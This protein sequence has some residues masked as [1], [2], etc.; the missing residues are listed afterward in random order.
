MPTLNAGLARPLTSIQQGGGNLSV[1]LDAATCYADDAV[2]YLATEWA[3]GAG[4][5]LE[6]ALGQEYADAGG[7]LFSCGVY[8]LSYDLSAYDVS[9]LTS[10]KLKFDT[11][12]TYKSSGD[13]MFMQTR[14][15]RKFYA[16]V[17]FGELTFKSAAW[18]NPNAAES[19]YLLD[20][21]ELPDSDQN[22]DP[23]YITDLV[24]EI[25]ITLDP[26]YLDGDGVLWLF[27]AEKDHMDLVD[28]STLTAG[29][30]YYKS[31]RIQDPPV[32]EISLPT[33]F[34]ATISAM[35]AV[36]TTMSAESGEPLLIFTQPMERSILFDA[37]T[38]GYT[39]YSPNAFVGGANYRT[40]VV[41]SKQLVPR[42]NLQPSQKEAL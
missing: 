39:E 36:E 31:A 7:A 20:E 24:H 27:L 30:F 16:S 38:A 41:P 26:E 6:P 8:L 37:S 32:L 25:D 34:S 42:G 1:Y 29:T 19:Y 2:P 17:D 18:P 14:V 4:G 5:L 15:F 35:P 28:P 22:T 11:K 3:S 21:Y 33:Y 13:P 40:P 9:E 10:V 23:N 12:T